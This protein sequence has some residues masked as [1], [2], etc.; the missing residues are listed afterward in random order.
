M[1]V[2][3]IRQLNTMITIT[4]ITILTKITMKTPNF[5]ITNSI[6]GYLIAATLFLGTNFETKAQVRVPFTQ[7]TA[8]STPSKTIYNI[9]GDFAMFGNTNLTLKTYSNTI[10]ND[11]EMIFVDVDD[12]SNTWNSSSS[13]LQL[14]NENGAD[15][16][17]SK[18]IFAGLYW[19]G[20]SS[21]NQYTFSATKQV[22]SGT[23]AINNNLTVGHNDNIV[24]TNYAL[25]ISRGGSSGSRFPIYSF[26]GNGNTYVFN[27]TN[28]T[29]SNRVTLSVNGGST[30]NIPVSYNSGLA[31][32][33]TPYIITD[34]TVTL[35]INELVRSS[36][37]N[38]S[39]QDTQNT[40]SAL[41]NVSGT[42]PVY[43]TETKNYDKRIVS[44]KGPLAA[45]YTAITANDTDI[46][47]PTSGNDDGIYVG[48][49]EI[50]D[51]VKLNGIGAYFVADIALLEGTGP[52]P[53]YS[54]GWGMIVVYENS[55]MNS[56]D[57]TVFDGYAN[58]NG[59]F[60]GN[61]PI[62]G[63][64]AVL[65]GQVNMKLGVMASEGDRNKTGNYL[66]V[67]QKA[68]ATYIDLSHSGNSTTNFFNSSIVT[69][70]NPRNPSFL[71]NTGIDLSMFTIPNAGNINIANGQTSTNFKYGSNFDK[72]SIFG[73]AMSVDA[74]VPEPEGIIG[75]NSINGVLNPPILS[76]LP[77]QIIEYSLDITNNGTE[78]TANTVVTIPIPVT[79]IFET[80]SISYTK[81]APL[82]TTNIPYFDA[83]NNEIKWNIGNLPIVAGDPDFLLGTLTFQ[84]RIT[85]DCAILI[86][87][88][89]F[90]E[91]SLSAGNITGQ[92]SISGVAFTENFFQGYDSTSGC[93]VPIDGSIIV[94][95][96][97][98]GTACY[99]QLA[100]PNQTASCGL[101]SVILAA[102]AGIAGTWSGGGSGTFSPN[103][104]DPN[105][106]F[107]GDAGVYNLRWTSN[108][109]SL[110][111]DEVEI[112][113]GI[114]D[115]LNFDGVNDNINL[116]DNYS[117]NTG[118]FS[119]ETWIKSNALT[120]LNGT[121]QS[122]ISKRS[123]PS[124]TVGY[125]LRLVNNNISF[126]WNNGESITSLY[127]I[128]QNRWYHVAVTFN[129]SEY[130][131]YIDGILVKGSVSGSNPTLNN[132]V[133]CIVGTM[134]QNQNSTQLQNCFNGWMD[135][136][137]IWTVAL[138]VEQIRHMMN[139]EIKDV[140]GNVKGS[141][142]PLNVTGLT[143]DKLAGYYQMNSATDI[144]NGFILDKAPSIVNGKLR[145]IYNPQAETAPLPYTTKNNGD[146]KDRTALT[147]WTYGD[148][149][150]D[151]PNS[152]GYNNTP[153]DWNIVQTA[154][155]ITSGDKNITVLGLISTTGKLSIA[156]PNE[157]L[158]EN[159]SG[160]SL[161]VTHYLEL[162][163]AIDLVG[164]SQLLQDESSILDENSA[165]YIERD[166]QG[167]A[168][169]FNY[170]YW[171][172]S[173][174]PI[175]TG[176]GSN[177]AKYAISG[178]LKD[179]T[180]AANPGIIDFNAPH[181]WADNAYT[182]SK[183]ISAYWLYT[184]NGA[185]NSYG[186]WKSINQNT[187]L[188]AGEGYTMKGTSG[189]VVIANQQNYVFKGKPNNGDI[190]LPI[191]TGN[192]RLVG[193]PY[194]SAMDAD[195]FI[196]D[197][198]KETINSK[199][200][201]NTKNIFNGALYFWDHFGQI[202]THNLKEYVG[203]Y[204]TYNLIGGAKAI[205]NDIRVNNNNAIGTKIP[206]QYI[207]V[208]QGFFVAASLDASLIGTTTTIDGG[209]IIFKNSQ[210]VFKTEASGNSV[211]MKGVN[212]KSAL[213]TGEK[214][215]KDNSG[216]NANS[217]KAKIWLQ[218]DS[219]TGY[220]RQLLVGVDKNAS[221]HFDLGYDA[222][223]ADIGKEDMY[224]TFDGSKFVIQGVNN[225]DKKQE[226]PLGLKIFKAGLA[227]IKIDTSENLNKKVS[228]YIK[229]KLTGIDYQI[230]KTP[231]EINLEP[232]EYID[233]F[234]V[235][236]KSGKK[237]DQDD[238]D[239]D[240][241][242]ENHQKS[243][244]DS[245][246]AAGDF[247]VYMNNTTAELQISKPFDAEILDVNLYNYLGQVVKTWNTNLNDSAIYLPIKVSSGAYIVQINA[248]NG[249][250]VKKISVE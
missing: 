69:G 132:G 6:F 90:P 186:A 125:D 87:A 148:S 156:E 139:Q 108:Y 42:I 22:Q 57:V 143:W 126:N 147:P 122:I 51:Y 203:G 34:G 105:A 192:D 52:V 110:I 129:G 58:E 44:L 157:I 234:S 63:F 50:T 128:D 13:T 142:V 112:T 168:N 109:C 170:N 188:M 146:W 171:S 101:E 59:S 56:R 65:T 197:N 130:N 211:F 116:G 86:N 73:F 21:N 27:Y 202:N 207:P 120:P 235:T 160:Q 242:D 206:Q 118:S 67:Q 95:I 94:A 71:N 228:V 204:A 196:K 225:F 205:S 8:Q 92:G 7:R 159:N 181:T 37:T 248:K 180:N 48:Y 107:T 229:D 187:Q 66:Q 78:P 219:P 123:G 226:L 145:N 81:N 64:K 79:S 4:L 210:R 99:S 43:I 176:I 102:T 113:L 218:F 150:W 100:G 60:I 141:I 151:Y 111:Y 75:V 32:L 25:S 83:I 173:V 201:R 250:T 215:S 246:I 166:Q 124:S 189:A 165:G 131:L 54:G 12:D 91:I 115:K 240:D 183:R 220:H 154:H 82:A 174:G 193:N 162:D 72:F 93:D 209:D 214:K 190:T 198:I 153:I 103:N 232:G 19:T 133:N 221:N 134:D 2:L 88:G 1:R 97:N 185:D 11:G 152:T 236:F 26:S 62:S 200:G 96:D 35:T 149:V 213:P 41:V 98:S 177:N 230:D 195:E 55:K 9:K 33:S 39:T 84:L 104:T 15:P 114:C 237:N 158:N 179:G 38:L 182:G 238:D 119:I 191:V 28:N 80:G 76:I 224:W 40:S 24:N 161:R 155:D 31:T 117:L 121:A 17:C 74:Y 222:P 137:R 5:K 239:D 144:A 85:E 138:T 233:R 10:D 77:G 16:N 127:P 36:S 231:F 106:T 20:K 3:L 46:W 216:N 45:T 172:S 184:F 18:I 247:F 244:A 194:S 167:T 140:G 135:E 241:D 243:N 223:I 29:G 163:G 175:G 227:R 47:Y 164:E 61:I 169:S 212:A 14:S 217:K 23:Q 70:G 245:L 53:G 68:T 249:N 136:M 30:I 208:G 178:V 49:K 199:A 89:C